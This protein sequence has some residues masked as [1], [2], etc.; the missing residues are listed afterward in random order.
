MKKYAL[1]LWALTFCTLSLLAE[2]PKFSLT[3]GENEA[4]QISGPTGEKAAE[5]TPGTVGKSVVIGGLQFN[6]SFG[7][8]VNGK[9]SAIL[10]PN[11]DKPAPMSFSVA[12]KSIETDGNAIVTLIYGSDLKQVTIDP[13]YI[14]SVK[15]DGQKLNSQSVVAPPVVEKSAP[16]KAPEVKAEPAPA[17]AAAPE[18]AATPMLPEAQNEAAAEVKEETDKEKAATAKPSPDDQNKIDEVVWARDVSNASMESAKADTVGQV[19]L[20]EVVGDVYVT[21]AAKGLK[22]VKAESGMVISNGA[23]VVTK[24][25]STVA[26]IIGGTHTARLVPNTETGFEQKMAGTVRDTEVKLNKGSVFVKVNKRLGETQDFKVRTPVGV[27]AAKGS[28]SKVSFGKNVM[29]VIASESRWKVVDIGG[30]SFTLIPMFAK[31]AQG[32]FIKALGLGSVPPSGGV[33]LLVE[34][35]QGLQEAGKVNLLTEKFADKKNGGNNLGGGTEKIVLHQTVS[36]LAGN[37]NTMADGSKNP[38]TG[39]EGKLRQLSGELIAMFGDYTESKSKDE[40]EKPS[41]I[42][43]GGPRPQTFDTIRETFQPQKT[44]QI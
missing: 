10:S 24:E 4:L 14:G 22:D 33:Q 32:S 29:L 6:A 3:I 12:G 31:T 43:T 8:D 18:V 26:A 34:S 40:L 44:T 16:E 21:D 1:V 7:R 38:N 27:A 28:A 25:E 36:L 9:L 37:S 39:L 42:G 20:V 2:T 41:D 35:K 17:V 13:G 11:L 30:K 5:L 15:V 23:Q 19:R